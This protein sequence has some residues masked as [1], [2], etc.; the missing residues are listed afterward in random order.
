MEYNFLKKPK[1]GDI[2]H[3]TTA[4]GWYEESVVVS[5]MSYKEVWKAQLQ[6]SS[7]GTVFLSSGTQVRDKN[8]WSPKPAS[9]TDLPPSKRKQVK[10]T[11]AGNT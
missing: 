11:E 5:L 4:N 3:H 9:E 8:D 7:E 6:S 2:F 10:V 1:L